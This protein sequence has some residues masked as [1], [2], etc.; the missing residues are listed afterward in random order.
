M[1][2]GWSLEQWAIVY[3]AV[4]GTV[5]TAVGVGR[6]RSER[7]RVIVKASHVWGAQ[8]AS[9]VLARVVVKGPTPVHF[10]DVGIVNHDKTTVSFLTWMGAVANPGL[11]ATIEPNHSLTVQL[12]LHDIRLLS[13]MGAQTEPVSVYALDASGDRHTKKVSRRTW[14]SWLANA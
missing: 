5:G 12:P 9:C 14:R 10:E 13:S 6:W 1:F 8:G 2:L 4:T 11:P 7:P 3:A